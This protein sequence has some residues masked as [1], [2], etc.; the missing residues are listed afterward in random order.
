MAHDT[1]SHGLANLLHTIS[2]E[3]LTSIFITIIG[4][5]ASFTEQG[6]SDIAKNAIIKHMNQDHEVFLAQKN[7]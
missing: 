1:H 3:V 4:P 6:L 2:L 7:T 5:P